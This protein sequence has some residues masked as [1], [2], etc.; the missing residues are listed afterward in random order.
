M[1]ELLARRLQLMQE[2]AVALERGLVPMASLDLR[3]IEQETAHQMQVCSDFKRLNEQMRSLASDHA[4][5]EGANS[6]D[7]RRRMIDE[8]R[9]VEAKVRELNRAYAA[10]LRRAW[11]SLNIASNLLA[12]QAIT[13]EQPGRELAVHSGRTV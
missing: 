2:I 3:H 11:Q 12:N 9:K 8:C 13:Y 1:L 7:S 6:A 10:L 4:G 5:L